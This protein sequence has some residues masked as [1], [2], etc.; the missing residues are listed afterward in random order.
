[1]KAILRTINSMD[2]EYFILIKIMK[3]MKENSKMAKEK[4]KALCTGMKMKDMKEIGK[5]IKEKEEACITGIM[6]IEKL[7]IIIIIIR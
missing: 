3:D 7:G 6:A 4:E 5:I 2:M 1:M